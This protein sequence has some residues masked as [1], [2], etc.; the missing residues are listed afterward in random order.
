MDPLQSTLTVHRCLETHLWVLLWWL[1]EER[2][3]WEEE[4][5]FK[6]FFSD[7]WACQ[8]CHLQDRGELTHP[9]GA[10]YG[11]RQQ[12]QNRIVY[13]STSFGGLRCQVMQS[14]LL[15]SGLA[16]GLFLFKA[17]SLTILL[18]YTTMQC[19]IA[20][21]FT[22]I[23]LVGIWLVSQIR[24][25]TPTNQYQLHI[26][27]VYHISDIWC[28]VLEISVRLCFFYL[29]TFPPGFLPFPTTTKVRYTDGWCFLLWFVVNRWRLV[30]LISIRFISLHTYYY[31]PTQHYV[32]SVCVRRLF[33]LANLLF[34]VLECASVFSHIFWNIL[35]NIQN[36]EERLP[37]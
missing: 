14:C 7:C 16:Y 36:S 19:Y 18:Y 26:V 31:L 3:N 25:Y 13:G 8:T 32:H 11:T 28:W 15:G 12:Q 5:I 24:Q 2:E 35:N 30:S 23:S 4:S 37:L 9:D 21:C 1:V 22:C 33:T 29:P 27:F 6:S 10:L 17:G 20:C 34:S